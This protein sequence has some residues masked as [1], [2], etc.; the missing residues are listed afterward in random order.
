[1]KQY[2]TICGC[3]IDAF[4]GA[5]FKICDACWL[6]IVHHKKIVFSRT[7]TGTN[8]FYRLYLEQE[9]Q[10]ATSD[11]LDELGIEVNNEN[12]ERNQS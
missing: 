6:N 8:Q 5:V 4:S 11:L 1:M 3:E 2:C 10:D 12:E 9:A 7:P